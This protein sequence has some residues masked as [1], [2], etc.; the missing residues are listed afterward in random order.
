MTNTIAAWLAG[1][2]ILLLVGDAW[3][4]GTEHLLYLAKKFYDFIEWV[5]FWR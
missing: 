2:I 3:F 4:F 1:L 5:A